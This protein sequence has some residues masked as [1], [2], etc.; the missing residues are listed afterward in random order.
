MQWRLYQLRP[1]TL[2][3]PGPDQAWE[4]NLTSVDA[5]TTTVTFTCRDVPT[6][7]IPSLS[8]LWDYW[9]QTRQSSFNGD[10][11]VRDPWNLIAQ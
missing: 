2:T 5:D 6:S 10:T 4:L 1:W 3:L 7:W 9:F 8:A 11:W